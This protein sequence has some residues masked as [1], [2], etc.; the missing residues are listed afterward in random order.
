MEFEMQLISEF[1][2][3]TRLGF[4]AVLAFQL[5]GCGSG[6]TNNSGGGHPPPGPPSITVVVAPKTATVNQ[7]NTQQFSAT[8]GGTTNTAVTWSIDSGSGSI[9]VGGLYTAP[10]T[11]GTY[12]VTVTTQATP[13]A[14]DTAT[15]TVVATGAYITPGNITGDVVVAMDSHQTSAISPFIYGLNVADQSGDNPYSAWG[16]YLP[17]FTF[18]RYGGNNTTALN[19]ETGYTNAGSD[20]SF[21][22]YDY[23]LQTAGGNAG[24][25]PVGPGNAMTPRVDFSHA[26]NAAQV[27]TVP[28]IGFVAK[29]AS[30]TQPIPTAPN[31][32]TPA[33][34][35]PAH[36]LQAL[37]SNPAGATTTPNGSDGFV[38]TDDFVKWMDAKYPTAKT[39]PVK[40]IQYELDNEPDIW[41]STHSEIRG[42]FN[43][44]DIPTGFDELITKTV[45]H[46]KAVKSVVPNAVVWA[47]A[48][49]GFDGLTQLHYPI[50]DAPP[51]GYV[52]YFDYFLEKMKLASEAEGVRLMD[53]FDMHWY[54][55]VGG[56]GNDYATQD[57]QAIDDRE[58]S[59]RSLWD[60]YYIEN[61]W[62]VGSIPIA[63]ETNC[64]SK[65]YC[66]INILPRMQAHIDQFYPGTKIAIGEYW[67]G[68]GGDIS[69]AITNA[70]VLGIF[71]KYG[72]YAATMWPN[73]NQWAYNVPNN[74]NND[75][76]CAL[77]HGY[78]CALM[79]IDIYRNYDGNN[80]KF[81]D[82]SIGTSIADATF[83]S[84]ATQNERV[85]AYASMDAGNPNRVVM[86][87]INKA[88]T[89]L[90][91]GLKI[92]HTKAFSTAEVWQVTGANGG[93]GGCT[94]PV[95]QADIALPVTNGFNASLPAQSV[96]VFVLK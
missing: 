22:N 60:P 55:Q 69:S 50:H 43:G 48:F 27:L 31:A 35:D 51:A 37:A 28:I 54:T 89:S 95:R 41:F 88:A 2:Q 83:T 65:G 42:T 67:Y 75:N 17:K 46:A 66:P 16:T 24:P 79:A 71:G 96:T 45:A 82:T 87:A 10:A 76:N 32:T 30:G 40:T 3:A 94:A 14:S 36:W 68:R 64:N 25:M 6:S 53:V 63:D 38:Y 84:P 52:Y 74:C 21:D 59:T 85:T 34:P 20:W 13:A 78:R 90:N 8:V 61:S 93:A 77:A 70:D 91:T 9:A 58:Q 72:V 12:S 23:P 33:T 11:P 62:I 1:R 57:A 15:V 81:G 92:T 86:V 29:D 80:A 26:H 18:N 56:V 49:S 39:D 44:N 5:V 73:G 4:C 7:G 19:W 47:G